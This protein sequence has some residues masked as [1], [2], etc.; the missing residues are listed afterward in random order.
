MTYNMNIVWILVLYAELMKFA[1]YFKRV[2][3]KRFKVNKVK[4]LFR[5]Q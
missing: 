1:Y 5:C 3:Y 2:M 4:H